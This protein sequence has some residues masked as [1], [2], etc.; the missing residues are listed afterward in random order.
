VKVINTFGL[1][2]R[3]NSQPAIR[4]VVFNRI[5]EEILQNLNEQVAIVP[6]P[7]CLVAIL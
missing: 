5:A 6:Q 3:V 7:N 4:Q 1:L 2:S